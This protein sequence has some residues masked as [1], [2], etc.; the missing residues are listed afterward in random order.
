VPDMRAA[1][2]T[3]DGKVLGCDAPKKWG[4]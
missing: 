4:A 3:N 1:V 2:S